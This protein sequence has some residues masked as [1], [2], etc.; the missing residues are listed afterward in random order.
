MGVVYVV[1]VLGV[2]NVVVED[3]LIVVI[4]GILRYIVVEEVFKERE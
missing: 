4:M 3:L 2:F 1:V